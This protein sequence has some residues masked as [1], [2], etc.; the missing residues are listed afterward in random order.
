MLTRCPSCAT[1]FRITPEQLKARQGRVRCGQCQHVFNALETLVEEVAAS[2]PTIDRP[3]APPV[4]DAAAAI[5]V[6]PAPTL[7]Q[8]AY[9]ATP[10]ADLPPATAEPAQPVPPE[11]QPE[12]TAQTEPATLVDYEPSFDSLLPEEP[13]RR[14]WPWV[15]GT[16]LALL[17]LALQG[18][19]HYRIEL[20]VV[21]PETK[22]ALQA[23]CDIAGC[24]LPLPRKIH[25]VGIET[26]DLHP[27]PANA[28]QLQLSAALK[29][30]APFAQEYPHLELTLT[31]T[32]DK[33]VLRRILTPADYLPKDKP[34]AAGFPAAGDLVLNL[35]LEVKDVAP[36]GYRLYV[37]YP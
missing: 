31:D 26:S 14:V 23:L 2:P 19:H 28:L 18:I 37:F 36:V 29:N 4:S 32:A 30:R 3:P 5:A 35:S 20:A 8:E 27:D 21:A 1:A 16:L 22:P 12:A 7:A 33:A 34:A 17:A 13:P 24:D 25:L 10:V 6:S 9:E 15:M 11:M